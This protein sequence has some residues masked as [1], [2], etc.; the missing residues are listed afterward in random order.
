VP[1]G[2]EGPTI[3]GPAVPPARPPAIKNRDATIRAAIRAN[4][5]HATVKPK[6]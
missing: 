2:I 5:L 1:E 4:T 3:R 6:R